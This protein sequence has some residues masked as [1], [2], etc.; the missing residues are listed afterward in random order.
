MKNRFSVHAL[1]LACALG[2]VAPTAMAGTAP[3]RVTTVSLASNDLA[4]NA[5]TG[6]WL[7]SV[8]S[9]AGYGLG[10]SIT[11]LSASG[12]ILQSTFVGSEPG[13]IALSSDG[14]QGYVGLKGAGFIRAFNAMTGAAQGQFA[15]GT[16]WLGGSEYAEDIAVSPDD[17][18]LIAV[19]L[20]NN[21]CSPRHD[22]VAI[23]KNGVAL[24][25]KTGVHTGSNSIEFGADG[26]VLYGYNNETTEFGFRTMAVNANGVS[27][28]SV[29][30]GAF[31]GFYKTFQYDGG[32]LFSS[33][34]DVADA[35]T[36][37]KIGQFTIGYD[38][39]FVASVKRGEAYALTSAGML[40]IFDLATYTP[41]STLNLGFY[42]GSVSELVL[43]A[44]GA[45]AARTANALYLLTPV[46][47]PGSTALLVLGLAGLAVFKSR[48][49]GSQPAAK[50]VA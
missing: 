32:L 45:L 25:N 13:V 9:S 14:S 6:E 39:S 1:A 12:S 11:R 31:A 44:D 37:L 34:G 3:Y 26:S 17:K 42:P 23:F 50:P 24:P 46:P 29:G 40:T 18:N 43:G 49:T 5:A 16:S 33:G 15:L 2:A 30:F 36:G 27:V 41:K 35:A 21:C 48:R 7:L 4:F 28:T 8:P 38:S 19:S 10:N 20:R 47:E 22:G